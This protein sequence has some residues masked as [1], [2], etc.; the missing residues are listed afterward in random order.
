MKSETLSRVRELDLGMQE[1]ALM[2]EKYSEPQPRTPIDS[3]RKI[4]PKQLPASDM[5]YTQ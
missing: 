3:I 2:D 5:A 4:W 1:T